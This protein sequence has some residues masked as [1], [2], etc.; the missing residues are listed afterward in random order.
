PSVLSVFNLVFP[1]I[2][3]FRS[4]KDQPSPALDVSD[5]DPEEPQP[6]GFFSCQMGCFLHP[7]PNGDFIFR[8]RCL[9]CFLQKEVG[10]TV[11]ECVL[12]LQTPW[13]LS[14]R[15]ELVASLE[16]ASLMGSYVDINTIIIIVLSP[17]QD[18]LQRREVSGGSSPARMGGLE[19]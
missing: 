11:Y 1:R 17:R 7:D 14:L 19:A 2:L 18:L 16:D 9:A 13:L 3:P 15:G 4:N 5:R 10:L 8:V 12:F 6:P